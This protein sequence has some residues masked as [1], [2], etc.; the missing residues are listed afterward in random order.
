VNITSIITAGGLGA[1]FSGET[2]KQFYK[3]NGQPILDLTISLFD[4][5]NIIDNIIITLPADDFDIKSSYL[6]N[7]FSKKLT[8][9][10]GGKTRQDSVYNALNSCKPDTDIVLIH[11]G[12]RPFIKETEIVDLI[13]LCKIHKAVIPGSKVKNTLKYV[14][15]NQVIKTTDRE[16]IIEVYT[17]QVFDYKL[18]LEYH[19]KATLTPNLSINFTDDASILEFFNIPVYWHNSD[20]QNIKI[21]TQA[22]LEYAQ[23]LLSIYYKEESN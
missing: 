8:C 10:I 16:N 9:I 23:Y 18:I 15:N 11:D 3:L 7:L 20:N 13:E 22:D 4:K 21:T 19:Q 1:R 14:T 12:V 2:K 17:P 5:L 6:T